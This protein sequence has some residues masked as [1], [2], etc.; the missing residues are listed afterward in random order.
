LLDLLTDRER[1]SLLRAGI[2]RRFAR[3]EVVFHEGDPGDA[4]HI[5]TRGAFIARSSSTM[6]ELIAVNVVGVGGVFGEMVLLNPGARR[7][8]TVISHGE[9][10]TLMVGRADV[11]AVMA[12]GGNLEHVLLSMMS[13]RN[14]ELTELLV[15]VLFAPV[16]QRVCRRLLA[17]SQAA[18]GTSPDGWVPLSQGELA[19]LAGTTR[20]TVNRVLRRARDDGLVELARGRIHMLDEGALRRAAGAGASTT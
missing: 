4:L 13:A 16:E 14:R 2:R 8:A 18:A 20:S 7:S 6:G 5:V 19:T 15:E 1:S 10:A 12:E 3:G 11:E 9:G 17:F